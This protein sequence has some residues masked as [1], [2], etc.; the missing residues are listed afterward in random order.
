MRLKTL[1][2]TLRKRGIRQLLAALVSAVLVIT[3]ASAASHVHED[4]GERPQACALCQTVHL[5][6]EPGITPELKAPQPPVPALKTRVTADIP[7][8]PSPPRV[9]FSRAPP[10]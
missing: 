3:V 1:T 7:A 4:Y 2:E 6:A 10:A 5:P 9:T 8:I